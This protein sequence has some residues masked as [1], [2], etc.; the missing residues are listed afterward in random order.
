MNAD[1]K[2]DRLVQ[3]AQSKLNHHR[4]MGVRSPL[5]VREVAQL[6]DVLLGRTTT[7]P[8]LTEQG[9]GQHLLHYN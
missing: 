3:M 5:S 7:L 6:L 8:I 2:R 1:K 4:E 9:I